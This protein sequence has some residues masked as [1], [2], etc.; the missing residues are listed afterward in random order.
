MIILA[1]ETSAVAASAAV[2]KDSKLL[3]ESFVN[4]GLTH[5]Q[6]LMT[7]IDTCLSNAGLGISDVDVFAC[8][9]GPGSFT[10]IRIGVSAV[11]GLAFAQD[12]PVYGIS[13]L[14]AMAYSAAVEGYVICPV[15]DAR[16][17]QVYTAQ[18]K[19]ENGELIRLSEDEPLKLDELEE[20]LRDLGKKV[21]FLGDGTDVAVN[22][23]A[24]K[25]ID[26]TV[27]PEIYKYQHASAVAIAAFMRY[28]NGEAPLSGAL[29]LPGYLRL[30]QAERERNNRTK[31]SM[32]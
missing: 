22:Y 24:D 1:I 19:A 25:S 20:K 8:A 26:F 21:L 10:G 3:S 12:K 9:N 29:L 28:N 18:F 15:M 4:I 30:S 6:T 7:L 11:K 13:T 32:I 17:R 23:F 16:C 31:E 5:S 2:M 27:F 14:E